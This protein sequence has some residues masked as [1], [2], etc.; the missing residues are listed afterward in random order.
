MRKFYLLAAAILYGF[1]L[2]SRSPAQDL[3]TAAQL[4]KDF[5]DPPLEYRPRTRYWWFGGAVTRKELARELRG[6]KE[7]GLAGV[8]IQSIYDALPAVGDHKPVNYASP[9]WA[10]RV[11][12]CVKEAAKLGMKVDLTPG[13]GWPY[14]GPWIDNE[15]AGQMLESKTIS[16]E[17]PEQQMPDFTAHGPIIAVTMRRA[18][19]QPAQV[20]TNWQNGFSV[21]EG[22]WLV[23]WFWAKLGGVGTHKRANLRDTGPVLDH[24][25][26]EAMDFHLN[27]CVQ[28][29]LDRVG[30]LAGSTF[31]GLFIDSWELGKPTWTTDFLEQFRA[32]RGYNLTPYLHLIGRSG[33]GLVAQV[34]R[35]YEQTLRDLI[36]DNCYGEL[37]RWSHQHGLE[38]RAQ[39]HGS[40]SDWED[41]YG[42]ADIP[43]FEM[44]FKVSPQ[45]VPFGG[46]L[47]VA[48]AH[49]YGHPI[50][51][52][53]S[54]TWL[55]EHW[56]TTMHELREQAD[57]IFACGA[58][59]L[60]F[61]G[62]SYSP[63]AAGFPGWNFYA[64]CEIDDNSPFW[65]YLRVLTDYFSRNSLLLRSGRPVADIAVYGTREFPQGPTLLSDRLTDRV[66]CRLAKMDGDRLAVG[67][68]RYRVLILDAAVMPL[69]TMQK[70]QT[71]VESGFAVV[72]LQL[73][74]EVPTFKDHDAQT[75]K[76]REIVAAL[77][78]HQPGTTPQKDGK[79]ATYLTG[80]DRLSSILKDIGIEQQ[81]NSS[82]PLRIP[83][84]Q[85]EGADYDLYLL[86]NPSLENSL[87]EKFSFRAKGCLEIWN[88]CNRKIEPAPYQIDGNRVVADIEIGPKESR[89]VMIR[90]DKPAAGQTSRPS[91]RTNSIANVEGPWSVTFQHIDGRKPFERP[92]S[93]LIDWTGI[94]DL[95]HFAGTAIYRTQFRLARVPQSKVL[96]DLGRV[97]DVASVM[98]NGKSAGTVFETPFQV[99]IT[100]LIHGGKNELVVKVANRAENAIPE[101]AAGWKGPGQWPGYFFVNRAYKKYDPSQAR[102]HP[103]GLLGPVK[104]LGY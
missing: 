82:E 66:L 56:R 64:A 40:P 52:C 58:N 47:A 50:V 20:V 17:G 75:A 61:H 12:T 59:Q 36:V 13:S 72:A 80:R 100:G 60:V 27:H 85:R 2:C 3:P 76:L 6:M 7:E 78:P 28:P 37:T 87:R 38:S 90:R 65:A 103:S 19:N 94:N 54:F 88:A 102:V 16:V 26:A 57:T 22:K 96:L 97:C 92:F 4:E 1:L 70:I 81:L 29:V 62:Y 15:H 44:D 41:S 84:L 91:Q 93:K 5:A 79:G 10:D 71:F 89:L 98:V 63:P 67:F 42:V 74:S 21:P 9:E 30:K 25:S 18:D 31:E 48:A 34:R 43:E 8:E 35:D 51:S 104:L 68:G 32:R 39:A 77:F 73:P 46:D 45:N 11:A 86:H 49:V 23:T 55:T 14:A 33:T 95:K 53:E 83:W 101:A 99:E 69:E 24:L